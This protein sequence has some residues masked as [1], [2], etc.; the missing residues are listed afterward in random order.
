MQSR[1]WSSVALPS[2]AILMARLGT[3]DRLRWSSANR[4]ASIIAI[5][6]PDVSRTTARYAASASSGLPVSS[7]RRASFS[8]S[9]DRADGSTSAGLLSQ[10]DHGGGDGVALGAAHKRPGD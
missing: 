8:V 2:T 3:G 9:T 7:Y 5:R 6:G 1:S 10:H 4:G